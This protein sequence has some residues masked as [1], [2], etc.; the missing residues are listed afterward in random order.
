MTRTLLSAVALSL[1]L[2]AGRPLASQPPAAPGAGATYIAAAVGIPR[3]LTP[4][5]VADALDGKTWVDAEL[6][7]VLGSGLEVGVAVRHLAF[8]P[9]GGR[10][11]SSASALLVTLGVTSRELLP[12][13]P[14]VQVGMGPTRVSDRQPTFRQQ[15]HLGLGIDG[16]LGVQIPVG[17]GAAVRIGAGLLLSTGGFQSPNPVVSGGLRGGLQLRL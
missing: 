2:I 16:S 12:V 15:A 5:D 6:W 8:E 14:Y 9:S 11:S 17:D 1:G 7:H 13:H 10:G 4:A 3:V